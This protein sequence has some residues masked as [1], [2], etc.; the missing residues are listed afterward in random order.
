M[1]RPA[2]LDVGLATD[3]CTLVQPEDAFSVV[4]GKTMCTLDF[5][6]G[7]RLIQSNFLCGSRCY[8]GDFFCQCVYFLLLVKTN[9]QILG[10]ARLGTYN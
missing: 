4:A 8:I 7:K 1:E 5:Y 10:S 9:G 3:I 6:E 2:V